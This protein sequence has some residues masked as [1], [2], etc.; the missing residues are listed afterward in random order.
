MTLVPPNLIEAYRAAIYEIDVAGST[1]AL[2]IGRLAPRL[3]QLLSEA[4]VSEG[5]VLTAY[6]PASI[7]LC[8][9]ENR[10]AHENLAREIRHRGLKFF[11]TRARDSH[12]NWPDEPGFLIAGVTREEATS[13]AHRLGQNGFVY[14]APGI[15]PELVLTR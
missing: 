14:V 15:P 10:A 5:A 8:E 6:N 13:L 11:S 7:P 12:G 4:G 1:L 9:A 2:R 3:D